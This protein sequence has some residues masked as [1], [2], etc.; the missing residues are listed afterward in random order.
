MNKSIQGKKWQILNET[1]DSPKS[2]EKIVELLLTNRGLK[3][4]L[5][6]D[7]FLSPNHPSEFS[8]PSMGLSRAEISKAIKRIEKSIKDKSKIIIYGDYDA[9]GICAAG[10]LWEVLNSCKAD[11]LPYIPDRFTEGYGINKDSVVKLKS[12]YPNLDLIIT[13]DNGIS[14]I[15]AIKYAQKV[16]IDV[17][18]TDHHE[19]GKNIPKSFATIHTTETSGS[20]VAWFLAREV[21]RNFEKTEPSLE[22]CAIGT[23]AD[24]LPILGINRSLIKHGLQDLN[25]TRRLGL[26]ALLN[27]A[28]AKRGEIS[29]FT[30]GFQI[31]PRLNAMGRLGQAI[32]S[33][34]LICTKN[35]LRATELAQNMG[36]TNKNRQ[37][38]V[39]EVLFHARKI[40]LASKS[41]FIV[42]S[43][44][45]YHEGVIGLAAARLVEEFYR[46]AIVISKGE[47]ISKASARSIPGVNIIE[48]IRKLDSMLLS[49]G[50]HEMAAG[51]SIETQK[52]PTFIKEINK[53]AKEYL[54][55]EVLAKSLNVDTTLSFENINMDLYSA[56]SSFEPTGSGNR[57][58]TFLTKDVK[59]VVSK[60][61]GRD[62]KH[63]KFKLS[64]GDKKIGAIAFGMGEYVAS[65]GTGVIVD[66]VYGVE[67][68]VWN[69]FSSLELKIKDLRPRDA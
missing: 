44:V 10:I 13:V 15:E 57:T 61:V 41:G 17:I 38:I 32:D 65:L 62:F 50:G 56:L 43:D 5:D 26:L 7:Q 63:I 40:S 31:A 59:V 1:K 51:F 29:A 22:L 33:L 67:E 3:T 14:A 35:I 11:V 42:V 45:S 47:T 27:E 24:Q 53:F 8:L 64:E 30:V 37:K 16:G 19:K 54:T 23:I 60:A 9:D 36:K 69:G 48:I 12:F 6:K 18:V 20:G 25:K 39:E 4:K 2:T 66:V 34:R 52:I 58:P 28:G 68:N 21:A 55:E 49:G 46:P